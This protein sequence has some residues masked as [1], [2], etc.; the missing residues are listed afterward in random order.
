MA[1]KNC[2]CHKIG[3]MANKSRRSSKSTIQTVGGIATGIGV[4]AVGIPK[5]VGMIDPEGKFDTKLVN[6]VG[7][8]AAYWFSRKQKGFMQAALQG[9]SAGLVWNVIADVAGLGY[10]ND[11]STDFLNNVAGANDYQNS[12]LNPGTI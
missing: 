10:L 8:G 5:V 7:A 1:G 9:L 12:R 3:S 11:R 2:N 4:G 6:A